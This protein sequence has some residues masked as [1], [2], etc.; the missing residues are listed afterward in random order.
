MG[1]D[2][3]F[4]SKLYSF[5]DIIF[6]IYHVDPGLP[7][8]IH[9]ALKA[10]SAKSISARALDRI[11]EEIRRTAGTTQVRHFNSESIQNQVYNAVELYL[12]SVHVYGK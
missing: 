7:A 11:V 6:Q 12:N 1:S 2:L 8:F 4:I 5:R 3:A 9:E 10:V